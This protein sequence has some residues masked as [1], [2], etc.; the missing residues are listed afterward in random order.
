VQ[1]HM[2][3]SIQI[4]NCTVEISWLLL[5]LFLPQRVN[6]GLVY[7]CFTC[8]STFTLSYLLILTASRNCV[9]MHMRNWSENWF[10]GWWKSERRG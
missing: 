5:T 2:H 9:W 4:C 10:G 6:F 8:I 1:A 3:I 7:L